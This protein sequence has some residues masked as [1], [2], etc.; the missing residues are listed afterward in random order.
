MGG[1]QQFFDEICARVN[2]EVFRVVYWSV[3]E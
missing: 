1:Q 2:I 3:D